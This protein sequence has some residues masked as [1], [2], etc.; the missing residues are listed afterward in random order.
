MIEGFLL[1]IIVVS[2]LI[3]GLFFLKFWRRTRDPLFLAFSAAF[4]IEGVN[5]MGFL[6]V[7]RP[8]EGS[9]AIY[10]VRLFAFLIILGAIVWK[11]R[12]RPG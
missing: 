11:N 7:D 12:R 1:G 5:R 10:I 2:S 6:F 3:A 9:P 4:T 8:N